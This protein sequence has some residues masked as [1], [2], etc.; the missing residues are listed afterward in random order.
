MF[1]QTSQ[2]EFFSPSNPTSWQAPTKEMLKASADDMYQI[3]NSVNMNFRDR[4]RKVKFNIKK[5]FTL[6]QPVQGTG[7]AKRKSRK[8]SSESEVARVHF[9]RNK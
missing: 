1:G 7:R 5:F 6:P 2:K 4:Q 8:F 9:S 3:Q